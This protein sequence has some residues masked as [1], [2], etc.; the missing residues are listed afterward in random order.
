MF[1]ISLY[2]IFSLSLYS[3]TVNMISNEKDKET[4]IASYP[5]PATRKEL[6]QWIAPLFPD[7]LPCGSPQSR[8]TVVKAGEQTEMSLLF[9]KMDKNEQKNQYLC[10]KNEY[11][12]AT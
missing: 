3:V 10:K 12:K 7:A 5:P 1:K 4:G 9:V 2:Q 6:S 11:G 8:R